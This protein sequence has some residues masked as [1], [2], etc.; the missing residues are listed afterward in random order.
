MTS[1]SDSE[2]PVEIEDTL[3]DYPAKRELPKP[4]KTPLEVF[5]DTKVG[6]RERSYDHCTLDQLMNLQADITR[7]YVKIY[8]EFNDGS[9]LD[10]LLGSF[11]DDYLTMWSQICDLKKKAGHVPVNIYDKEPV[12]KRDRK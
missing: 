11:L 1:I 3:V 9:E 6:L 12:T 4:K 2:I 10:P 8:N 7:T 5:R